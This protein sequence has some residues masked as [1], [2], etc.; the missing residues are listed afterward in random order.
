M[1]RS[2]KSRKPSSGPTAKPKLSKKELANVEKRIRKT[3][4]KQA[5][6][7][8][9]EAIPQK[10]QQQAKQNRDPRL[11]SKKPIVLIKE[12]LKVESKQN[13]N[14][15]KSA[16]IATVTFVETATAMNVDADIDHSALEKEIEVIEQDQ[17]LQ[18]ILAKQEQNIELS[19][20]EVDYYNEQMERHQE[21]CSLL[22]WD[23]EDDQEAEQD[24]VQGKLQG[25][26]DEADLWDKLD[27][28]DL[29]QF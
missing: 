1:S 12:T 5:G 16:K 4:G 19:E 22:G 28:S 17:N 26:K 29:S 7:R 21:I 3:K 25:T 27:N 13:S 15:K 6:N 23:E 11:G 8:Q 9:Q 10:E 2:K 24:A 20:H 18:A 14:K